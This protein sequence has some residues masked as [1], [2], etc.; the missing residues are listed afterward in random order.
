ME[1]RV[2]TTRISKANK[3][4]SLRNS[5]KYEDPP[6]REIHEIGTPL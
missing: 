3:L 4:L 6:T 2:S 1:E 5:M